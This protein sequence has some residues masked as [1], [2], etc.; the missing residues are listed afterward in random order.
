[1][2]AHH[3]ALLEA[4]TYEVQSSVPVEVFEA[5]AS[6]LKTQTKI[7]V[8]PGNAVSLCILAKEFCLSKLSAECAT[9]SV[10]VDQFV[11]LCERVSQLER[12]INQEGG[13][14]ILGLALDQLEQLRATSKLPN[15]PP[16]A[17][18]PSA[19]TG[20]TAGEFPM[21]KPKSL[22]GIIA[23]LT[24]KHGG[25]V[26]ERGVVTIT[27]KSVDKD[28]SCLLKHVADLT[29]DTGFYSMSEPRQWACWDF[30]EMRVRPTHYTLRALFLKSWVLEGSL[31]GRSWT[32]IDRQTGN[33]VFKD[34]WHT[35]SF[36]VSRPAEC[37]FIRLTQTARDHGG[38]DQLVLLAVEFFGTLT[39]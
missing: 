28:P 36:A 21:K 25:N 4:K 16:P 31:D 10:P 20:Q 11:G 14:D 27:S 23:H 12:R 15:G 5:F 1:L 9:F 34:D 6:S 7:S 18:K 13:L 8:T 38:Y 35:T 32:E 37:R 17:A 33:Q 24:K 22:E 30:R 3:L 29:T 19:P 39:E 2:F 26:Q